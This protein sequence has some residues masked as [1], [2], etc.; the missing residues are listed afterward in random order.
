[1]DATTQ[2][3]M[4]TSREGPNPL[5]PYYNPPPVNISLET[6]PLSAGTTHGLGLKN[7]SA[8]SYAST[9]RNMFSDID[10]SDLLSDSSPS[11]VDTATEVVASVVTD[12][13]SIF[14]SQPFEI[15]KM[16]LQVRSHEA[17]VEETR[18]NPIRYADSSRSDVCLLLGIRFGN[19][20]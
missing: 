3:T 4:S 1:M 12:Y 20:N 18:S 19:A 6:A 13:L 16:V 7:G 10:Y 8:S 5:R 17:V 11:A 2:N 14:I 15:G 9:A